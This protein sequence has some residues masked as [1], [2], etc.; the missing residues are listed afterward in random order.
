MPRSVSADELRRPRTEDSGKQ[1]K[2]DQG[3]T[4]WFNS[5]IQHSI[6]HADVN[7]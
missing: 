7:A 2:S 6:D 5:P 1:M 4:V 3:K